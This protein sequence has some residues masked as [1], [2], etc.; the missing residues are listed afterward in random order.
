ME[1]AIV[2]SGAFGLFIAGSLSSIFDP[3]AGAAITDDG[4]V[5]LIAYELAV[6]LP[7]GWFLWARGWRLDALGFT[8]TLRDTVTGLGVAVAAYAAFLAAWAVAVVLAPVPEASLDGEGLV[9]PG[10]G[11][12]TVIAV[13]IINPIFEEIFVTGYVISFFRKSRGFWF[14]VNVSLA[15]RLLYHLYQ[16]PAGVVGTIPLGFVFGVWYAYT[17]RLWPVVVAHGLFDFFA[18]AAH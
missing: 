3:P 7:L 11:L 12:G 6:L 9:A 8:P 14:A 17:R 13:S 18:L 1:F 2:V 10:L 5:G 16:G 15:I 4:L